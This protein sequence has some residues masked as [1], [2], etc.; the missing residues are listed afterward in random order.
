MALEQCLFCN[1]K[2]NEISQN[3]FFFAHWD[4]YPVSPGH[5]LII[6]QEHKES[7]FELSDQELISLFALTKEA[8]LKIDHFYS[9]DA[10]NFGV[11]DGTEAGRTISHLHF[12]LIPRYKGDVFNPNGGIRHIIPEKGF[13]GK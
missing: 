12:H 7:F 5:V 10:Y 11:N 4:A 9:P 1:L 2:R 6:S 3:D 13:Y 8:K